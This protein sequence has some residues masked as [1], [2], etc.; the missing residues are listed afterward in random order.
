[1]SKAVI[2]LEFGIFGMENADIS[3][4]SV[5]RTRPQRSRGSVP[6]KGKRFIC[7]PG[8]RPPW[9]PTNFFQWLPGTPSLHVRR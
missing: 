1:M 2:L 6:A 7:A 4:A 3:I 9:E 5:L 8:S